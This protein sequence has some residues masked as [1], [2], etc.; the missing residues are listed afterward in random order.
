M[1]RN[2]GSKV[3]LNTFWRQTVKDKRKDRKAVRAWKTF[4]S[5]AERESYAGAVDKEMER[6]ERER[7]KR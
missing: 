6:E 1:N 7:E 4:G 3:F 5:E 2:S